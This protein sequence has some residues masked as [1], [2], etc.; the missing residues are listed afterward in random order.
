MGERLK[1]K[2]AIII[3]AGQ[4]PGDAIGNG[5]AISLLFAREGARVMLVD[6]RLDSAKET[7]S[8][9]KGEGGQ[10]FSFEADITKPQD[11]QAIPEACL[12]NYGQIDI[13]VHVVGVGFADDGGPVKLPEE[14]WDET[15]K[16]NLKGMF[17]TLKYVLPVMAKQGSGSIVLMSSLAAVGNT[18]LLAYKA[19]KAGV[20]ALT[21]QV[22]M[23]YARKGVRVNAL[24]PGFINTPMA[25]EGFTKMT[26]EQKDELQRKRS[27]VTPLKG[28]MGDA[29]DV[30]YAALFL[31]SD[32][33]KF[34]TSVLLPVDGGIM[35]KVGI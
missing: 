19:S 34:I 17:L 7:E 11:C 6:R 8:I 16:V 22:A 27:L 26:K 35:G 13:L 12:A 1:G 9:I 32:E 23:E 2:S 15:M 4:T 5:R 24:M 20:N 3:G 10:A 30:A 25:I 33:A 29:W 28:G 18:N 14:V 21:Q 31:A